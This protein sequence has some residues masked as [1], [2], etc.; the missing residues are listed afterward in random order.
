MSFA[1]AF[2]FLSKT[3]S[4]YCLQWGTFQTLLLSSTVIKYL[5]DIS[6]QTVSSALSWSSFGSGSSLQSPQLWCYRLGGKLFSGLGRGDLGKFYSP[7]GVLVLP[8][9]N[10]G[11][12]WKLQC[13]FVP[14]LGPDSE[15][16]KQF[17]GTHGS[18]FILLSAVGPPLDRCV[19]VCLHKS[20]IKFTSDD[21]ISV[22]SD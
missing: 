8:F 6:I 16:W 4:T 19:C 2:D 13:W 5:M 15:L 7:G 18:V 12:L 22:F 10:D 21:D 11:V 14:R 20:S 17:L 1:K 9:Q 3:N